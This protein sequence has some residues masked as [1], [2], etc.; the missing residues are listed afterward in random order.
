MGSF[1]YLLV[2]SG[3]KSQQMNKLKKRITILDV[4][5][6]SGVTDG[7]V[8]RALSGDKRVS[9]KTR[10]KILKIA[11]KLNYRPH[12]FARY[13]RTNV[14]KQLGVFWQGGSWFSTIITMV[15]C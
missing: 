6:S 1:I 12:L 10:D 4:A 11:A 3:V 14:T 2:I 7:T 8:S 15:P 13:L 5:K 9:P